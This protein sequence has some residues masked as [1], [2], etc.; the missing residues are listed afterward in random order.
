MGGDLLLVL[1]DDS[2]PTCVYLQVPGA[3]LKMNV[4]LFKQERARSASM[5][6][7]TLR[8]VHVFFN[9]VAQLAACHHFHPIQQRACAE[10]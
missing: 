5:R 7:P 10:C 9:Q 2:A 3:S 1:G 8:Y 6:T 4:T